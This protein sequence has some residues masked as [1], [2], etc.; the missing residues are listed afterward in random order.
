MTI[1]LELEEQDVSVITDI[2]QNRMLCCKL[3][4]ERTTNPDVKAICEA[5]TEQYER[6]YNKIKSTL[7]IR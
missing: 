6:V 3:D 4:A 2:L 7:R 5:A 1:K